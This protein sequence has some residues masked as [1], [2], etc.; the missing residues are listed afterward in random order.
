MRPTILKL[1]WMYRTVEWTPKLSDVHKHIN[2]TVTHFVLPDLPSVY[3]NSSKNI[4]FDL[5][6][7]H[8]QI[9]T[10]AACNH[11]HKSLRDVVKSIETDKILLVGGNRKD[12]CSNSFMSTVEAAKII[13][14]EGITKIWGVANPN[15]EQSIDD[16]QEKVESGITGFITQ[17]LLASRALSILEAYQRENCTTFIA[18]IAMPTNNKNLR[19]WL[20]LLKQ[21][22][23]ETDPLFKS[24]M[25]YF[26]SPYFNSQSWIRRELHYLESLSSIDGIH[27]MPIKNIDDLVP[28]LSTK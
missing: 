5:I 2:A 21:P 9:Q 28:L 10:I 19:Y 12:E 27:F 25:T 17:P 26:Q 20:K 8:K 4:Y 7:P 6:S 23:L 3:S 18:G 14:N 22:D 11:N 13:Q 16:V 24:H 15:D 1:N